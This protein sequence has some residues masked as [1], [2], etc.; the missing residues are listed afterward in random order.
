MN[1]ARNMENPYAP[2]PDEEESLNKYDTK[3]VIKMPK[4]NLDRDALK[5]KA[6]D[7]RKATEKKAEARAMF[8]GIDMPEEY[9]NIDLGGVVQSGGVG[10][11]ETKTNE[12]DNPSH[13]IGGRPTTEE[14]NIANSEENEDIIELSAEKEVG[15]VI[16]NYIYGKVDEMPDF[17]TLSPEGLS[18]L[19]DTL[20]KRYN[21]LRDIAKKLTIE[22]SE[23]KMTE[24]EKVKNIEK[25]RTSVERVQ[26]IK[27]KINEIK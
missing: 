8:E 13:I 5:Q 27:E 20:D 12:Y 10:Y 26:A 25:L 24:E 3:K 14:E 18:V 22:G 11:A 1:L 16:D 2:K 15:K 4:D 6:E 23:T 21:V 9:K 19:N 17:G 7:E